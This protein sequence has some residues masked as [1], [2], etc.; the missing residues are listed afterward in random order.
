MSNELIDWLN[1]ELAKRN[2]S[3]RELAKRAHLSHGTIS[4]VLAGRTNPGFEFC[5]KVA[6][7]LSYP[8][9]ALLRIAGLLP[10]APEEGPDLLEAQHLFV[11]LSDADK[12]RVLAL[13]R[14]FVEMERDR[15]TK[16]TPT[17]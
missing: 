12:D 1:A 5:R 6:K 7:A 14:T 9:D 17:R 10:P 4:D 2:W 8:P 11:R 15:K 16:P 3:V 13:M